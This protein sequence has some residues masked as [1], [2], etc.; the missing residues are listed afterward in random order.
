VGVLQAGRALADNQTTA[1]LAR[2]AGSGS[3]PAA[4]I[5][6]VVAL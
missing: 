4:K 2:I 3:E 6:E 5:A 1:E